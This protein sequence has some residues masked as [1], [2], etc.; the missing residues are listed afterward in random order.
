M[1]G[2]FEDQ[3]ILKI[4]LGLGEGY[5]EKTEKCLYEDSPVILDETEETVVLHQKLMPMNF[6]NLQ[7]GKKELRMIRIGFDVKGF[8]K[9]LS[10]SLLSQFLGRTI[11]DS[12]LA[13][14]TAVIAAVLTLFSAKGLVKVLGKNESQVIASFLVLAFYSGGE[15]CCSENE[16]VNYFQNCS[17]SLN[18]KSID[19]LI[20]KLLDMGIISIKNEDKTNRIFIM[21]DKISRIIQV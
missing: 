17:D 18:S 19:C 4:V 11:E 16:I 8:Y 2:T 15:I 6:T 14:R 12:F 7:S 9:A 3:E 13:G 20:N 5:F 10:L 21:N 1:E